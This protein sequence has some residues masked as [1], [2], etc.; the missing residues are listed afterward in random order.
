MGARSCAV[1]GARG[2]HH[3]SSAAN[4]PQNAHLRAAAAQIRFQGGADL[5][6][7]GLGRFL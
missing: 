1:S 3:R 2:G 4:G 6:I 7:A 5:G